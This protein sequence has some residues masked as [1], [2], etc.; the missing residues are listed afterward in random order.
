MIP[1][2]SG[3]RV[4]EDRNCLRPFLP[5][6]APAHPCDA[7]LVHHQMQPLAQV[8]PL[9]HGLAEALSQE[10]PQQLLPSGKN[11]LG[12]ESSLPPVDFL[13]LMPRSA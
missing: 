5:W 3:L 13:I 2:C 7:I 10:L 11:I 4:S 8:R 12:K 9:G 6:L 1:L